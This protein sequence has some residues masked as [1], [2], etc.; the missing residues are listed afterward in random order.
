M[1]LTA[2]KSQF[3]KAFDL[4][5]ECITDSVFPENEINRLIMTEI[6][7]KNFEIILV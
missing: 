7:D 2:L 6:K 4:F 3:A 1:S 5:A